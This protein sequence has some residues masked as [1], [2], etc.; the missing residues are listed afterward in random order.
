MPKSTG[1]GKA[2]RVAKPKTKTETKTETK[3]RKAKRDRRLAQARAG[4]DRVLASNYGAHIA[5]KLLD[6]L[7]DVIP[8][9]MDEVLIGMLGK[10]HMSTK[11]RAKFGSAVITDFLNPWAK[12]L[13]A[14]LVRHAYRRIARLQNK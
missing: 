9:L 8:P 5:G 1:K 14:L 6:K 13:N 10:D 4:V 11:G 7:E 3:T 2:K 12:D